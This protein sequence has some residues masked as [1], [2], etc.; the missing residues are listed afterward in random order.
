[1]T[2]LCRGMVAIRYCLFKMG[3]LEDKKF[4]VMIQSIGFVLF[5]LYL[6]TFEYS[7]ASE[8]LNPLQKAIHSE[9]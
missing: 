5:A 3:K 4:K 9:R 2:V 8:P 7:V 6:R 1:M